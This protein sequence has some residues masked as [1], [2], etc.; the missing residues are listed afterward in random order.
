MKCLKPVCCIFLFVSCYVNASF[1]QR[2]PYQDKTRPVETRVKDLISRMTTLE[3]IRQLDMYRGWSICAMGEAHEATTFD[4]DSVKK[5][6]KQGSIGSIHD[7]YPVSAELANKVQQYAVK[8]TRLGIPVMFIEEGL[9]GY[10]GR[11]STSFPI[12]LALAAT[13]DTTMVHHIGHAIATESRAHGTDMIL[14]PLLGVARD[15]RWGRMEETFGEDTHLVSEIGLA[16]VK[17]LQGGDVSRPDAVVSEPKHFAVHP[18]PEAGS[19]TGPV[20]MGERAIRSVYL[21]SF[22]KAVKQ[23]GA[24]GIMA[25]YHEIDGVPSVDNHW[26]LTDILRKDWGFKGM[27]VSDLGAIKMSLENHHVAKDKADALAQ[28]IKAGLDMQFYDFDHADFEKSLDS[29]VTHKLLSMSALDRAVS[30]VLRVKFLLGLFDQPYTDTSLVQ[31]V[32]HS[33][34]HQRLALK[35]AAEAAVLL[36]NNQQI[37]PIKAKPGKKTRIALIG[38]LAVSN[39]LGGYSNTQDTAISLLTGLHMRAGSE[40]EINYAPGIVLPNSAKGQTHDGN[41]TGQTGTVKAKQAA[42]LAEALALAKNADVV[43]VALGEDPAEVGEGKDRA[44]LDLSDQQQTLI[45]AV[46]KTGKPVV[47]VLF[48]GR[49][50]CIDWVAAHVPAIV[51]GWFGGEKSG[52]SLADILLGNINPSG[53]LPVTFPRSV[54]QIPFYYAHKPTSYHRYVDE[55]DTPLY[56]FGHGLSYTTFE[57]SHLVLPTQNLDS[58]GNLQVQVTIHNTGKVK[59]AEVVQLYIRDKVSSVTTPVKAL[60]AFSKVDLAPG[61]SQNVVFN[62]PV[63]ETLGLWNRDMH[64]VVEPGDFEIMV[65]SSSKDIRLKGDITVK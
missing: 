35:A 63:K 11:G 12:S 46:M 38:P 7:F 24:L 32:V 36:K 29:A 64:Y 22:E 5:V 30:D 54:G 65:G 45:K 40:Y 6:F 58:L 44:H 20:N 41:N 3:K 28:T 43:V 33:Q 1:A 16:M 34:A 9:H 18:A 55:A 48:N 53:K 37:L 61:A 4:L 49:P 23:G 42:T 19:N 26:L 21:P 10:S 39:Y 2:Y 59:G 13:W 62:L 57:Y 8:H 56:A 50:I 52:L 14:G 15:P 31:K 27:V 47:A 60:K 17:G 51:E 25:A